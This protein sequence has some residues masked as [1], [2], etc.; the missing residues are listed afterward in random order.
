MII[1]LKIFIVLFIWFASSYPASLLFI[2][3]AMSADKPGSS[4]ILGLSIIG[5]IISYYI[6]IPLLVFGVL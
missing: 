4:P 5:I 2:M 1:L 6:L 3:A